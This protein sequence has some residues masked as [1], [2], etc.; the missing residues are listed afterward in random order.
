MLSVK[1][2]PFDSGLNVLTQWTLGGVAVIF[3]SE[4]CWE[5]G[6]KDACWMVRSMMPWSTSTQYFIHG[7]RNVILTKFSSMAVILPTFS[8]SVH[9]TVMT[10]VEHESDFGLP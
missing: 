10:V 8:I 3:Y 5:K 2:Q 6:Y 4:F 9:T 1:W 7:N